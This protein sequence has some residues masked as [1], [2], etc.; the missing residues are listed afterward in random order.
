M[1]AIGCDPGFGGGLA[2]IT[3]DAIALYDL[4]TLTVEGTT[5]AHREYDL[6]ALTALL[7]PYLGRE[8][9]VAIEY[10]RGI[11]K[12]PG[13]AGTQGAAS[14]WLQG[15]GVGV[16]EGVVAGLG[17]PY[18]RVSP[19]RWRKALA[20]PGGPAA[21][22]SSRLLAIQRFPTVAAQLARKKDHGR[23]EALHLAEYLRRWATG[24]A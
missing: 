10:V 17:L 3:E 23:A 1:I 14:I 22:E 16:I 9:M 20:V 11:P 21:K 18:E 7:R 2:V 15:H 13:L 8:A 12:R 19:Q 6:R 5:K 24:V 4:P